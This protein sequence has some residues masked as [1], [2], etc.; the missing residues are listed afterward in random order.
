MVYLTR[1]SSISN[2]AKD[3]LPPPLPQILPFLSLT[4]KI[5]PSLCTKPA[6]TFS[7]GDARQSII[8]VPSVA[9]RL[10]TRLK[11]KQAPKGEIESVVDEEVH[12]T[13]EELN[14]FANSLR[15]KSGE[16]MWE[17]THALH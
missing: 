3:A 8:D 9:S 6:M 15:Q 1:G 2:L 16:Y 5:N 12:Y 14:E 17:W 7:K 11:A 13:T 4:E 10:I